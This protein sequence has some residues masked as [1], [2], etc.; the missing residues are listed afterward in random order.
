MKMAWT[1]KD[2]KDRFSELVD[3]AMEDGPQLVTW[4]GREAVVVVSA[5]EYRKMTRPTESLIEFMQHSPL[6][7]ADDIEF[8]RDQ[9][10]VRR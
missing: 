2:A 8:G 1:L 3:R 9:S 4:H 10:P 5:A 6:Y 7:G